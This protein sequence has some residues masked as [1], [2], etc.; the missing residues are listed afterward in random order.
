MLLFL[1]FSAR[2]PS[3]SVGC[4]LFP[5]LG[6]SHFFSCH[7]VH[8]QAEVE[9][10]RKQA[11]R[12]AQEHVDAAQAAK[13]LVQNSLAR[14]T[15]LQERASWASTAAAGPIRSSA[16]ALSD[17]SVVRFMKSST[18]SPDENRAEPAVGSTW[19]GPPT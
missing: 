2:L 8:F 1:L 7:C 9:E 3:F 17:E 5:V 14:Q 11:D 6:P 13:D 12:V 16:A 10:I 4:R 18:E 15:A 19:F